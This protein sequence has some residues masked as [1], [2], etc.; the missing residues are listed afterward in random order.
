MEQKT[1][2]KI[3]IELKEK[4]KKLKSYKESYEDIVEMLYD[5][6]LKEK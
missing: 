5:E 2:I 1:T 6:F 4:L 3:S